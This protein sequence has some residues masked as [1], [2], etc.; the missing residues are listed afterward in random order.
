MQETVKANARQVGGDHYAAA[1]Q[2]WDFVTDIGMP[3]LHAQVCKYLMRWRKKNGKQDVEKAVHF[4][5]KSIEVAPLLAWTQC[6]TIPQSYI[7]ELTYRFLRS[8]DIEPTEPEGRVVLI[9]S[10]WG[11]V[12]QL[13]AAVAIIKDMLDEM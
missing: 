13:E 7:M 12:E 1:Y 6:R 3:Y 11:T 9:L 10:N 4:L 5:E 8:N 2:H